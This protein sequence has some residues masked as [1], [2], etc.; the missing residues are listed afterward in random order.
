VEEAMILARD[1]RKSYGSVTAV[2]GVSLEVRRGETLGLL[3]PN[4]AGKTTTIH[5]LVGTLKPDS[6]EVEI[7]GTSDPTRPK[8]RRSIGV[9]PQSLALYGELT[10]EENLAFFGEL[11]GL[12]GARLRERVQSGLELAGLVEHRRR[13]VKTYSGGMQR[14]LNMACAL[15]HDPPVLFLDEPTVGVDPQSRNHIFENIE[16]LTKEGRTVLYTTHYMEEAERLCDRVAIM[17]RGRILA[18]DTVD[19]LIEQHGG[20]SVVEATLERPPDDDSELAGQTE[21]T[22]LRIESDRPLE[23]VARLASTRVRFR[24]LNVRRPDLETVF[25]ALTGRRLRD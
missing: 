21:G 7:D 1:L 19:R 12:R 6:G 3:G 9:A 22:Q 18:L 23:E 20:A 24:T 17:D 14:R 5:L 4:G 15:V 11:Y 10:G 16:A 8:A 13:R 2:D 25:L